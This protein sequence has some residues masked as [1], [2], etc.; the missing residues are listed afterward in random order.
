MYLN[1]SVHSLIMLYQSTEY[2]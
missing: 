1:P 2:H